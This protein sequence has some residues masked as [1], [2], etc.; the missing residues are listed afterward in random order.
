MFDNVLF[1][2]LMRSVVTHFWTPRDGDVVYLF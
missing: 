2:N 1:T